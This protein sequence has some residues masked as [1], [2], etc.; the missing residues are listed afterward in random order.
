MMKSILIS[1]GLVSS[2]D[3]LSFKVDVCCLQVAILKLNIKS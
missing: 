1:D 3:F 2:A